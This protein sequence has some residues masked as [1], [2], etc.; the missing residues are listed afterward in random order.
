MRKESLRIII[1]QNIRHERKARGI[2]IIELA[3]LMGLTPGFIGLLERGTR[4]TS[5]MTLLLLATI[6]ETSI[7]QLF[8]RGNASV[9]PCADQTETDE[10]EARR[11]VKCKKFRSLIYDF[12]EKEIDFIIQFIEFYYLILT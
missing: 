11:Q 4:G 10:I 1:G 12:D 3:E 7:D 9:S 5:P 8:Y 6:F 2:S